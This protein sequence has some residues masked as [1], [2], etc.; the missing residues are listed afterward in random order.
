MANAI[1]IERLKDLLR[2]S[3]GE[4]DTSPLAG[5]ISDVTFSELGYD[6]L[7]LIETAALIKRE[8]GVDITD[9]VEETQTPHALLSL[10]NTKLA[11]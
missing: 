1:T 4:E 9:D 8:Y 5:D 3:A 11:A 2:I 6:S 7:A 10:V